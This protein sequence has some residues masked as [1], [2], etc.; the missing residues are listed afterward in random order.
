MWYDRIDVNEEEIEYHVAQIYTHPVV[1]YNKFLIHIGFEMHRM[2]GSSN[3]VPK[4]RF[5]CRI[6]SESEYQNVLV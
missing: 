5:P 6:N 3:P 4:H 1:Q 2:V